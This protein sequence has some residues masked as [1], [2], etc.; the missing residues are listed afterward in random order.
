[1]K[2][3]ILFT[4]VAITTFC[5]Q[6]S[7]EPVTLEKAQSQAREY[8]QSMGVQDCSL[9]LVDAPET[10][11]STRD[12][13]VYY[14]V[15]NY[16]HDGGFVIISGD[17]RT[18]PVLAFSN[19]GNVS[20]DD[21]QY[22]MKPMLESYKLEMAQLKTA[23]TADC[24][25]VRHVQSPSH[26]PVS[27]MLTCHWSQ[28]PP[29]DYSSPMYKGEHCK[30]GCQAV[31]VAQVLYYYRNRMP[32]K[33]A[34]TI[35]GY[36]TSKRKI[37]VASIAKGTAYNWT[38]MV[39]ALT[40]ATTAQTSAVSKL[41]LYAGAAMSSDYDT[42]STNAYYSKVQSALTTYFG[43]SSD[44][45]QVK[46]S[47][48]TLS[49]WKE[50]LLKELYEGR[51]IIM[52]GQNTVEGAH[53]FVVDGFDGGEM[54]HVNWGH[55]R[56]DGYF[57]FSTFT[58]VQPDDEDAFASAEYSYTKN[59][60]AYVGIQP[61]QGYEEVKEDLTL[62]STINTVSNSAKTVTMS[63]SNKSGSKHNYEA[64]LGYLN[65]YGG[66]NI[67]K[68]WTLGKKTLEAGGTVSSTIIPLVVKDFTSLG[69]AKGTYKLYPVY[70]ADN[71]DDWHL[72]DQSSSFSHIKTEYASSGLTISKVANSP[73]FTLGNLY[74]PGAHGSG[75]TQYV[76]FE[77]TNDGDE[78]V[79]TLYLYASTSSSSMGSS[80]S[81][82]EIVLSRGESVT[83]QMLFTPAS[84]GTY[85]VW[86]TDGT[87]VLKSGTVSI[88]SIS[89][90]TANPLVTDGF[91]IDNLVSGS[92]TKFYGN[93]LKG[94]VNIK[95]NGSRSYAGYVSVYL[96]K[97]G[98]STGLRT[99][100]YLDL[101]SGET[102]TVDYYF[103]DLVYG[104]SYGLMP[105]YEETR[106]FVKPYK[107]GV[108]AVRGIMYYTADGDM[109]A[110]AATSTVSVPSSAVAVDLT[111][112]VSSISK[113]SANSNPNTLY[114]IGESETAPSGLSGKNVVKGDAASSIS[115]TDGYEMMV[116]KTFTASKITYTRTPSI[117]TAGSG[118]WASIVVP[119][120]VSSVTVGNDQI[121]WFK[122][123]TDYGK[124]F[125]VKEFQGISGQNVV[126]FG[127]AQEMKANQPY[128]MAVPNNHWGEAFNL[129]GK[130][131][132]FHGA[133]AQLIA[134]PSVLVGS[135]TMY[136]RGTYAVTN[137]TSTYVLNSTGTKF[138]FGSNKV[139][140]FHA[141]FV[142]KDLDTFG[143]GDLNIG[144]FEDETNGILNLLE[145]DTNST[146]DV[147]N[148]NGVKVGT[149]E[150]QNGKVVLGNLPRGIYIVNGKKIV[151]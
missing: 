119:F 76:N 100:H 111:G 106:G 43:F 81:K 138:S 84:K 56:G 120:N 3:I 109:T 115:L 34:V 29:Y 113:V 96:Y 62:M 97:N 83:A 55:G 40:N 10:N 118:G 125:W 151:R 71:E 139:K 141:F 148:V 82:L 70:R 95:N 104:T 33:L 112:V 21:I 69:L 72:C 122:S 60:A 9:T 36:V 20:N 132:V 93:V 135:E 101:K 91:S 48:Y 24:D 87:N 22:T 143:V 74:F 2:K 121:D 68:A 28:S 13:A 37:T 46:R 150:V 146:V 86:I 35:P 50:I 6:V 42:E 137:T 75:Y 25:G 108:S 47:A 66:V 103:D 107:N 14:Y 27:P 49:R 52:Y 130:K 65:E 58:E 94:T 54:F 31:A 77:V 140:P 44:I 15:F 17:D 45:R 88:V 26:S 123:D 1:M 136:F 53:A 102:T 19:E 23:E 90:S 144:S 5:I 39:D 92:T 59:L 134:N 80:R 99:E 128:I 8:L 12:E 114:Y 133:N 57:L 18:Q 127:Y 32:E 98:A 7:A 79:G 4:M 110:E 89:S 105:V 142:A 124:N 131:L 129:V 16:G 41:I 85:Y 38:K 145:S 73:S 149:A 51:P 78:G 67:L 63:F 116:P 147:Y 64:G 61:L 11:P 126:C 117:G 30:P